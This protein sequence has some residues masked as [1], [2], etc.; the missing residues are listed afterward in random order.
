MSLGFCERLLW[1]TVADSFLIIRASA[2]SSRRLGVPE[3][4]LNAAL[5]PLH[6]PRHARRQEACR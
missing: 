5:S 6:L 1:K 4:R 3:L 2:S